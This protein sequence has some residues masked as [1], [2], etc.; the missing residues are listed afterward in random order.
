MLWKYAKASQEKTGSL[1]KKLTYL[2]TLSTI[3][4]IL[5]VALLFVPSL[6]RTLS[7]DNPNMTIDCFKQ[8]MAMLLCVSISALLLGQFIAR[9]GLIKF[10]N[11]NK[12]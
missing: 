8:I 6:V 11:F 1:V 7:H 10:K 5:V 3:G 12:P 2:Y 4:L 9:R